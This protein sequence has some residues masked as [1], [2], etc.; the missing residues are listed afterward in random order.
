MSDQSLL[1][2][3]PDWQVGDEWVFKVVHGGSDFGHLTVRVLEAGPGGHVLNALEDREEWYWQTGFGLVAIVHDGEIVSQF[4][5]PIS[6]FKFPM[7]AGATWSQ[8]EGEAIS[9]G[10]T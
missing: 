1:A 10:V 2:E 6:I 8:G 3:A 4:L 9:S 5:P 7:R